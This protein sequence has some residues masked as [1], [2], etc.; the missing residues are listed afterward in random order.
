[1]TRRI[2]IQLLRATCCG[3]ALLACGSAAALDCGPFSFPQCAGSEAQ[4]GGG[5]APGV[6]FGGFGGGDCAATRTPVIFIHGNG[7]RSINFDAPVEA[8]P[9]SDARPARSIY[10]ELKHRGYN[11]CELYGVTYLSEAEQESPQ[12]NYHRPDKYRIIVSFIDAVKTYT[13][14]ERVDLVTHSLGV[15]MTLAALKVHDRWRDVRRFINIAG[16]IRGLDACLYTGSA[17]PMAPTCGSQNLMDENVFGFHP[18]N[19]DWTGEGTEYSLR[20]MPERHPQLRFYTIHAGRNDQIHCPVA[21]GLRDC[22][23]GPL[24]DSAP[25]V[26]AQLNIGAGSTTRGG[27][28]DGGDNDGVGHLKA[29][30]NAGVIIYTMLNTDCRGLNCKG[31]YRGAVRAEPAVRAGSPER[32]EQRAAHRVREPGDQP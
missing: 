28:I 32:S 3:L 24:F 23:R 25:N 18:R 29:R 1:V 30:N 31:R 5:F 19:N 20:E 10:D 9:G 14:S 7:D 2:R 4:Y 11:D 12:S 22:A 8:D 15:S 17:N 26:I 6:G 16:G 21:R 13:G 27:A